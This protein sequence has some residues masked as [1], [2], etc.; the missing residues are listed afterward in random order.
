MVSSLDC[1]YQ[2]LENNIKTYNDFSLMTHKYLDSSC[3]LFNDNLLKSES[4]KSIQKSKS[5]LV[6]NE[7]SLNLQQSREEIVLE[8]DVT[9]KPDP[10]SDFFFNL[11]SKEQ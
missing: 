11:I 8:S 9:T 10:G 6:N 7:N 5:V 3:D 2:K 4:R 1:Y